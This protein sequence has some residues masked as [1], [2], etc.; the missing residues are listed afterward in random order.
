MKGK[1]SCWVGVAGVADFGAG[2]GYPPNLVGSSGERE[3]WERGN[4]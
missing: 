4:L 3:T 1:T 2:S